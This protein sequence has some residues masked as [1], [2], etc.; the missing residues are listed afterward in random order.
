MLR[1]RVD[2]MTFHI[3]LSQIDHIKG[4][5]SETL[6]HG[7]IRPSDKQKDRY[8]AITGRSYKRVERASSVLLLH[9]ERGQIFTATQWRNSGYFEIAVHGLQQY[10]YNGK[11]T[12]GAIQRQAA[13]NEMLKQLN[14]F[15]IGRVDYAIDMP[16]IAPR[17]LKKLASK[18][19]AKP[20]GTTTYYQPLKQREREN[21][22]L[23]IMTYD[24]ALKNNLPFPMMRLEFALKSKFWPKEIITSIYLNDLIEVKGRSVIKRWTG[25]RVEVQEIIY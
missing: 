1:A 17:I 7:V 14:G 2:T 4:T 18:R 12:D 22:V 20:V 8:R 25:E 13:L 15:N 9:H 5:T 23:K 3:R 10:D 16:K 24:K 6:K 11:L 19:N 21:A